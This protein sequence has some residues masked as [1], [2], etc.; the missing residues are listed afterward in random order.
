MPGSLL[1]LFV[2]ES[3]MMQSC[4]SS[5]DDAEN[6]S[7]VRSNVG[8][9]DDRDGTSSCNGSAADSLLDADDDLFCL[10]SQWWSVFEGVDWSDASED[11]ACVSSHRVPIALLVRIVEANVTPQMLHRVRRQRLCVTIQTEYGGLSFDSSPK[12]SSL[13]ETRAKLRWDEPALDMGRIDKLPLESC[14]RVQLCTVGEHDEKRQ[15][16]AAALVPVFD[17]NGLMLCG[18]T[19][20]IRLWPIALCGDDVR[21][22]YGN[23]SVLTDAPSVTLQVPPFGLIRF[24]RKAIRCVCK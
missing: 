18:T 24:G 9:F 14:L 15:P 22:A 7:T 12:H 4:E 21:A 20:T 19:T 6:N 11:D 2:V 23:D 16:L 5:S 3:S 17:G 1:P 10:S 13:L 8:F